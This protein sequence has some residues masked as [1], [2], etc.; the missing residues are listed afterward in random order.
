MRYALLKW[1]PL[2][3]A[4]DLQLDRLEDLHATL[5]AHEKEDVLE[6]TWPK[7]KWNYSDAASQIDAFLAPR[8]DWR[9]VT[10][11]WGR[12]TM[13]RLARPAGPLAELRDAFAKEWR[14]RQWAAGIC[15]EGFIQVAA[16]TVLGPNAHQ[17][18]DSL[19][20][21]WA[22]GLSIIPRSLMGWAYGPRDG[23]SGRL[24]GGGRSQDLCGINPCLRGPPPIITK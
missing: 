22:R 6:M 10:E 21:A 7:Q 16:P 1:L 15:E 17:W 9:V 12:D 3:A 14:A 24:C 2:A 8:A 13:L 23:S 5:E 11:P 20:T 18:A 19:T 4:L